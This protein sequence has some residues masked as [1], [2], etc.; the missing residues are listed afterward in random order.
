MYLPIMKNKL[1]IWNMNKQ[2][3]MKRWN[4]S[5]EDTMQ[6]QHKKLTGFKWSLFL[7]QLTQE[8]WNIIVLKLTFKRANFLLVK[9]TKDYQEDTATANKT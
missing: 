2:K 4:S 7:N 9:L 6:N 8:K 5:L 3:Q 1:K